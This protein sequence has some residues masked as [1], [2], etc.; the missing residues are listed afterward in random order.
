MRGV[1]KTSKAICG[2]FY[3][4][5]GLVETKG[6]H[7]GSQKGTFKESRKG[8]HIESHKG[9]LK[10]TLGAPCQ[11]LPASAPG[12]STA[13]SSIEARMLARVV[14]W[15]LRVP[16]DNDTILYPK[17]LWLLYYPKG[18]HRRWRACACWSGGIAQTANLGFCGSIVR[19]GTMSLGCK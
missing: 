16:Y 12:L 17:A 10:G 13:L 7:K 8:T 5:P 6:T 9:A 1:H 3:A 2:S 18:R 11:P 19:F 14:P 15:G 4:L